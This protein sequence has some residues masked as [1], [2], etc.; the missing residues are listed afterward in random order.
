VNTTSII[1][2]GVARLGFRNILRKT[3]VNSFFL[4]WLIAPIFA[5]LT[6]LGLTWLADRTG[7]LYLY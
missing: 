6:S 3:S 4:I 1:G 5:F 7:I 2:I